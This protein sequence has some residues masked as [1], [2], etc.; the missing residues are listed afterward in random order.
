MITVDLEYR[1]VIALSAS[2]IETRVRASLR[3]GDESSD[4]QPENSLTH[5]DDSPQLA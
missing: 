1:Q 4:R 2:F 3:M 5:H